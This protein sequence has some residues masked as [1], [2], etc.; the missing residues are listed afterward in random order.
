[1]QRYELVEGTSSKFWEVELSGA[2]L[3]VRFG[4]IGTSGQTKTKTFGDASAAQREWEKLVKEK[5]GKGYSLVGSGGTLAAV[6]AAPAP[7]PAPAVAP[8]AAPVPAAAAAAPSRPASAPAAPAAPASADLAWPRG[9]F[10][11]TPELEK[12]IP[13]VR[14]VRPPDP[15]EEP[16]T[17]S[18]LRVLPVDRGGH[19][20]QR[21]AA[22]AKGMG[23]SWSYWGPASSQYVDAAALKRRDLAWWQELVAQFMVGRQ[24]YWQSDPWAMQACLAL[25]GLPFALEVGVEIWIASGEDP[26]GMILLHDLL[27]PLRHAAAVVPDEVLAQAEQVAEGVRQ[28]SAE[29]AAACAYVFAHRQDWCAAAVAAGARDDHVLLLDTALPTAAFA[30]YLKKNQL[31]WGYI[32]PGVLL[33]V[34]LHGEAALP[35]LAAACDAASGERDSER[36]ALALLARMRVPEMLP[37]LARHLHTN[38]GRQAAEG[39]LAEFGPAVLACAMQRTLESGD[40]AV[41]GWTVRTAVR[42]PQALAPALAALDPAQRARFQSILAALQREDAPADR[43]PAVLREPPWLGKKRQEELP[44]LDVVTPLSSDEK[45]E[46]D[47]QAIQRAKVYQ[48]SPHRGHSAG[49]KSFPKELGITA[50]GQQRLLAGEAL[51][52][53]DV[54]H[55]RYSSAIL[56]YAVAAPPAARLQLWNSYP[57]EAW[58]LW[59]Y[60]EEPTRFMLAEYG[61]AALPGLLGLVRN[62]PDK[63]LPLCEGIDSPRLVEPILRAFRSL[64]KSRDTADRW[65]RAHARTT[66]LQALPAAFREGPAATRDDARHGIR[67]LAANGMEALVHEVAKAYGPAMQQAAAALLALDPL[68]ALPARMPKL[69]SFFVAGAFRRPLLHDGSALPLAALEHVGVMLAISRPDAPYAGLAQVREACTAASLAEFAWDLFEAWMASGAPSKEG[70]AFTALGLLG[71]DETARRLAPRIRAWPGESAHARAV[72]GLDLLAAIGSDVALMHLNGIAGKV[73]FKAL[74]ERAKEK[75]AAVAE[76]RGLTAE[77]LADRLVPDLGLE[78]DGRAALDF[79]PRRFFVGFDEMLRPFVRDAEGARL[80]DLPKPNKADDAALAEAATERFKQMKKDAKAIA[81]LQLVR[82]EMGM[83]ARRRWR[84]SDFRLF[85]LEHPLMRHLAA[86]L[87]WG[88]YRDG[89]LASCFRVAEDWS[90]A[91]ARDEAFTLG[92][93]DTVG[94]AHVLEMPRELLDAFGQLFAD[95]EIQQPFRQLGRE[96]YAL[97]PEE[98]RDTKLTRFATK[99]VATGSVM[100]LVNRGWQR[101]QAQDA[102]WVNEFHKDVGGELQVDLEIDPGTVVGEMSYEPKQ[103]LASVTLR[104]RDTWDANGLVRFSELDPILASEVLRDLDLLAPMQE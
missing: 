27:E 1:M 98:L 86:R 97:T 47:A 32:E 15:P 102:G 96:T 44:F 51:R 59:Y 41:E 84:A 21:L 17:V 49:G 40:R 76:T 10:R 93:D 43:L 18:D 42:M 45:I 11:W 60:F 31:A 39:L 57:P 12:A 65:L 89:K 16:F 23:R 35:A 24:G 71:D 104:K 95:Y 101:G 91:D 94:I 99:V 14:G 53:G 82:L 8:V 90:L 70:W 37:H 25:H 22:I 26:Y 2:D 13:V 80:K 36:K 5:T 79:G 19:N 6:K 4:R 9:G 61:V 54:Q 64:K 56:E 30:A 72:T 52:D 103:K 20:G 29:H 83:V 48:P 33:Q 87:V 85:F 55:E 73:K 81:S 66:L 69:P 67:W 7:A 78:E 50:A 46:W 58:A 88:V 34:R 3:T 63:F 62:A 100:G 75:I 28:R 77:E 38:E 68:L 92:D 74:Q